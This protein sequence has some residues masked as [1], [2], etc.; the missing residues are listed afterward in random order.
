MINKKFLNIIIYYMDDKINNKEN[1]KILEETNNK[2]PLEETI[3]KKNQEETNNKKNQ[4]EIKKNKKGTLNIFLIDKC[5]ISDTI[6]ESIRFCSHIFLVHILYAI[7]DSKEELFGVT[8]LK[9]MLFTIIA[10]MLYQFILKK[11]FMPVLDETKI[12]CPENKD[13]IANF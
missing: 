10:I 4:E 5:D 8:F 7:I 3:N 11:M 2:K 9:T 1:N 12:L 13:V 6:F